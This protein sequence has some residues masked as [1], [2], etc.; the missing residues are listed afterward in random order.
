MTAAL[1]LPD[2]TWAEIAK[3]L[4]PAEILTF[5]QASGEC[6]R[7]C[8]SMPVWTEIRRDMKLPPPRA[9]AWKKRSCFSIVVPTA[10]FKCRRRKK[11][12]N[13]PLCRCCMQKDP[14][15]GPIRSDIQHIHRSLRQ[16]EN[17]LAGNMH[18][19]HLWWYSFSWCEELRCRI[20]LYKEE[21]S[22]K[23]DLFRG[24]LLS[25]KAEVE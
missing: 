16:L 12:A 14:G 20:R 13:L 3:H 4:T 21:A 1:Q 23:G 11:L 18:G 25:H 2:S 10:C 8:A 17:T 9:K 22:Y 24:L 5:G 7:L 6:R 15:M 19:N